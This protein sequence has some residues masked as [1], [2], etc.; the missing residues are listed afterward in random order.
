MYK[1]HHPGPKWPLP[2]HRPHF[3]HELGGALMSEFGHSIEHRQN[4]GWH[5]KMIE[6]QRGGSLLGLNALVKVEDYCFL[7]ENWGQ[8][9]HWEKLEWTHFYGHKYDYGILTNLR[10]TFGFGWSTAQW[11]NVHARQRQSLVL[12]SLPPSTAF[13]MSIHRSK[14]VL[15]P[16]QPPTPQK[17]GQNSLPLPFIHPFSH[18]VLSFFA[19]LSPQIHIACLNWMN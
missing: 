19:F 18:M 5:W 10:S 13:K 15:P 8:E 14:I 16:S 3:L 12:L 2:N 6:G 1:L 11:R 7:T 17:F 9:N 4:E